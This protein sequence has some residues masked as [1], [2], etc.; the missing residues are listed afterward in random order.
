MKMW[1]FLN[2][3]DLFKG[4]MQNHVFLIPVGFEHWENGFLT[5]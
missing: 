3:Y 2:Q 5:Q 4:S 1:Y